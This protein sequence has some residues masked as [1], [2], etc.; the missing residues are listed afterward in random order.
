MGMS[1]FIPARAGIGVKIDSCARVRT[2]HP[3][4][5]GDRARN[6]AGKNIDYGSS[7]LVR[8][9]VFGIHGQVKVGRF[10]PARAGIGPP[11][12]FMRSAA[13]VHPRSCGD[14]QE[15][16]GLAMIGRGSSPLVRGSALSAGGAALTWRFIPARAGIGRGSTALPAAKRGSSPLVRGSAFATAHRPHNRRFIPARAGIGIGPLS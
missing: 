2:V 10:I 3:R 6:A 8:G 15:R 12:T 14:R 16:W 7:P 1:R 13:A 9:S 11:T 4:S 5:C